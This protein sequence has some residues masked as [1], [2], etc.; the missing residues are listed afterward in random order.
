MNQDHHEQRSH[1][2]ST[3]SEKQCC[4]KKHDEKHQEN[5]STIVSGAVIIYICPMH[6]EIRQFNPGNCS[7][8]GMALEPEMMVSED[9]I[10]PE[11]IDIWTL[12]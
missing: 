5:S 8:C 12:D 4:H 2:D 9:V 11:Y 10:N 7:I 3:L 1:I 6:P